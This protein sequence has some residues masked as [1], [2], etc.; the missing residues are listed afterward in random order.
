MVI[1][2]HVPRPN[3]IEIVQG[4]M[5]KN[6]DSR[7]RA[8]DGAERL[9]RTQGYAATGLTQILEVSGAPKGSFYFHFPEGKQQLAREVL[10]AYGDRVEAGL[11][12]LAARHH[13][14]PAGF[15]RALCRGTAK[16]MAAGDWALGCAAQNLANEL[17]PGDRQFTDALAQT[18]SGWISVITDAIRTAY[19]SRPA[20][21]RRAVALVA[22]LEG[23][24]SLARAARS[25]A[26]FDA[27]LDLMM[28]ELRPARVSRY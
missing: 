13:G 14:D 22:A 20:A 5:E 12:G 27:V 11:R 8:L 24:R 7:A 19:P 2:I 9:F 18:F 25:E 6:R 10:Q 21:E 3:A 17:A 28:P 23:A 4:A 15:V 26:P 16:E 1:T